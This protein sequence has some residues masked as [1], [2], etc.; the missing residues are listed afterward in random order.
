M[1]ENAMQTDIQPDL[2]SRFI[3]YI[4]LHEF[5]GLL[6]SDIEVFDNNFEEDEFIITNL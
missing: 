4:Q 1:L 5:E 2:Q 6:F 3:P